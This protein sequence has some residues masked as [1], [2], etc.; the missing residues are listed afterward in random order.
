M[1]ED[2][3]TKNCFFCSEEVRWNSDANANEI[4]AGYDE[5]DTAVVSFFTCPRCGRSYRV[6]DPSQE[7]RENEYREYYV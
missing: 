6:A 3:K 5:D 2:M 1:G 4:L 7:E